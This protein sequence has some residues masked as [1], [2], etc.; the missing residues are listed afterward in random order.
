VI[1]AGTYAAAQLVRVAASALRDAMGQL[2]RASPADWS[3][4]DYE[5]YN[6]RCARM[7]PAGLDAL[8]LELENEAAA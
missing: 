7:N 8:A 6:E 4:A 3:D 1:D 5:R 2:A